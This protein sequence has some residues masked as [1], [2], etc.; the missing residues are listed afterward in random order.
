MK[1][2][3]SISLLTAVTLFGLTLMTAAQ[4]KKQQMQKEVVQLKYITYQDINL[5]IESYRSPE[6]RVACGIK[7]Q[8]LTINDYP[9]VIEKIKSLIKKIDVKPADIQ[10]IVQLVLGSESEGEQTDTAL[11][12]EPVIKELKSLLKYKNFTLLDTSII[13]ALENERSDITMGKNAEFSLSFHPKYIKEENEDILQ[14]RVELDQYSK[15]EKPEKVG[16][17]L[18][19]HSVKNL[20]RSNFTMK[21]GEKTVVGVSK[22]DGGDKGLILIITGKVIQ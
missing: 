11:K 3:I 18:R 9:E 7:S 2:F 4:E 15:F 16:D 21:S 6:G 14:V 1:R 20:I 8:I 5:L 12:D 22:L 17:S 19:V 13:R 10:F